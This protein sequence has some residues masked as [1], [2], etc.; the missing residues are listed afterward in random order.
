MCMGRS[1]SSTPAPQPAPVQPVQGST[2]PDVSQQQRMAAVA[3][4]T[5]QP[6]STFGAE[7]GK[8]G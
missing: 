5:T 7:L 3:T 4:S 8:G 1:K 6:Q 2:V